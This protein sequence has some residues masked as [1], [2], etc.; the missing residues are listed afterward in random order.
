MPFLVLGGAFAGVVSRKACTTLFPGEAV[1]YAAN[2][3][4]DD[5]D[6]T[7]DLPARENVLNLDLNQV[8]RGYNTAPN[9]DRST[10][11]VVPTASNQL[12]GR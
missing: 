1:V 2:N 11:M 5:D 3:D 6:T 10:T 4:E 7:V 9:T 12:A 8:N